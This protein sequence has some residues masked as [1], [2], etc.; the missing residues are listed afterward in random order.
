MKEQPTIETHIASIPCGIVV[1]TYYHDSDDTGARWIECEWH[2]I[3]RKGYRADW[4]EDK[5]TPADV[6][7]IRREIDAHF[8]QLHD[9]AIINR[10]EAEQA[11]RDYR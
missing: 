7:R 9:E 8:E 4:L 2:V 11:W 10:Y 6:A 3:D 5:L 1:D